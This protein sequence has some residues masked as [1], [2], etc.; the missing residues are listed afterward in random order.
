MQVIDTAIPDI[1]IVRPQRH[2]DA[3]G[4]FVETYNRRK[5]AELGIDF[6][7]VQDNLSLSTQAGTLR[8]LHYQTQPLAQAKLVS[9]IAG[10][11][12]D[13]AVDLRRGSPTLGGH[14][15][16]T[17]TAQSGEWLLVPIGFAHGYCTLEPG[18][19]ILYKVSNYY[20][21]AHDRGVAWNDPAF[22]IAWPVSAD[23]AVLSD[24]DR[25]LPKWA[26]APEDFVYP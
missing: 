1:K 24:K 22:G 18:T 5:F 19:Q 10:S 21:A 15:A 17:L 6:D 8:G 11:A 25:K 14:V 12:F 20:S 23:N 9:A 26:D 4:F 13:V 7:F 3:R 2:S 16:V